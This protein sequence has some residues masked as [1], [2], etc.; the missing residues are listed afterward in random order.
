MYFEDMGKDHFLTMVSKTPA[1][2]RPKVDYC[3]GEG[4]YYVRQAFNHTLF[5]RNYARVGKNAHMVSFGKICY[6][7]KDN[8]IVSRRE[9][10]EEVIAM[11]ADDQRRLWVS[12]KYGRGVYVFEGNWQKSDGRHL[13]NGYTVTSLAQDREGNFW[14]GTEGYGVFFTSCID[15]NFYTLPGDDRRLNVIDLAIAGNRLWLSSSDKRVYT[16][17]VGHGEVKDLH[18]VNVKEP[19]DWIRHIVVDND[20]Y[21]WLSSTSHLRYDPAGFPRPPDTVITTTIIAK[22]QGDAIILAS[23]VWG[24][25]TY[26]GGQLVSSL[27]TDSTRR[28]YAI[29]QDPDHSIWL[30]TLYGLYQYSDGV[31][32]FKGGSSPFLQERIGALCRLKNLLVVGTSAHGLLFLRGDSVVDHLTTEEG[33]IGNSVRALFV[34]NDSTLWVGMKDGLN[35]I[36]FNDSYDRYTLEGYG[37]S[38]G[39]P[40]REI[41]SIG[42]HDGYIWLGTGNGLVSFDPGKLEPHLSAP[43]IRIEGVQINGRDTIISDQY[44]LDHDQNNIRVKFMGITYRSREGVRYRYMLSNYNDQIVQTNNPWANFL[45]LSPGEYTLYV[46]AGNL[47]GIW[48]E[49]PEIIHFTIR[50]HYTEAVWFILLVIALILA[51]ASGLTLFLRRQRK[52]KERSAYELARTEQRMFRLQ[53]NPHFVFNALLAIQGYMYNNQPHE[54]GRYLTSFAKLIRHTLYGSTEDFI[55]LDKEVEALQYYLDLQ[56]MRFNNMF[57]YNIEIDGDIMP[58]AILIPPLLIQPFLE[59]S[60]EHGL[61]HKAGRGLL[62]LK[63]V[64]SGNAIEV[65][66][67]D[68]GIGRENAMNLQHAKEKLHKSMGQ[69]IVRKRIESLNMIM[70]QKIRLEI[71]DLKDEQGNA[72]GTR[73]ILHLPFKSN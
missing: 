63:I 50:K 10:D 42:M 22:G 58:E 60:I 71:I 18:R 53:M 41:N 40:S 34:Q 15:F 48:N 70:T 17:K 59:N 23:K 14:M 1:Y 25:C 20:G 6:Y 35:R 51:V 32:R 54:A 33:L 36:V 56:R 24:V 38:D 13:L 21:L 12:L 46:N 29:L 64:N 61:Q 9:F 44:V 31:E 11:L 65:I 72:M 8:E 4:K 5:H 45:N 26:E 37:S 68:N 28:V 39:L 30:G 49:R 7:I 52:I 2:C 19:Y 57:D 16:G 27:K 3:Y 62:E 47:H 73:V 67:D 69:D 43:M 55:H 66:I